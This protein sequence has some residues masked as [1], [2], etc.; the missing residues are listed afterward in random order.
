MLSPE[1]GHL[2][3][4]HLGNKEMAEGTEGKGLISKEWMLQGRMASQRGKRKKRMEK[5]IP[6]IRRNCEE[7][8]RK[9]IQ[10]MGKKKGKAEIC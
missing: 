7:E 6:Q 1:L 4:Q 10:R 9:K 3:D 5:K 2:R 8:E